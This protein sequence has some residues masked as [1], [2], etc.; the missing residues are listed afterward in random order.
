MLRKEIS[1]ILDV[2]QGRIQTSQ[3]CKKNIMMTILYAK[4]GEY[5]K[6]INSTEG[7]FKIF[8]LGQEIKKQLAFRESLMESA[9]DSYDLET[10]WI[11]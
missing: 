10:Q 7:D 4:W 6:M 5:Q 1:R 2:N 8:M 3:K 9:P 11:E